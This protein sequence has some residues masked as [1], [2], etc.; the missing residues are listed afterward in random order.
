MP[1]AWKTTNTRDVHSC[2]SKQ[3]IAS[4][5]EQLV[6][7]V[8]IPEN[9]HFLDIEDTDAVHL[10]KIKPRPY[11][12]KPVL[13][14]ERLETPEPDWAV[15]PN[16]L[17]EP[18]NNLANAFAT[19]YKDPE[20]NKLLQ[21]T[22]DMSPF[23]KWYC[24]WIEKSKIS[25]DDLEDQIDLVNLE[26]H[27]VVPDISKPLPLGGPPGQNIRVMPKCH[28]EDENP[29]RA[30]IKQALI[31]SYKDGDGDGDGDTLF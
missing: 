19:S 11:W 1:Q 25:K 5:S 8:P 31:G 7:Y 28:S 12:L 26:G 22:G 23:I 3:N 16:N 29:A 24:Q 21:K 6:E 27:R 30:N 14:E 15:P 4:Q 20:E 18:E 10:L 2:S 9:V 17:P 13:D